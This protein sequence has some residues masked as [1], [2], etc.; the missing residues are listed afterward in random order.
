VIIVDAGG[1]TI[2]LS[3]YCMKHEPNW[4]EE[5]APSTCKP[6]SNH[7]ASRSP[8]KPDSR[9]FPGIRVCQS[10]CSDVL[11]EYVFL[12]SYQESE[13]LTTWFQDKL[14]D[15]QYGSPDDIAHIVDCFDKST[16]LAFKDPSQMAFIRFGSTRDSDSSVDIKLGQLKLRGFGSTLVSRT[17]DS[18]TGS[19][20]RK[21]LLSLNP[22]SQ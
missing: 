1:G 21:W 15:S 20:D 3:A 11:G 16:K 17:E 7:F 12:G 5:I 4:F 13:R 18:L 14:Y 19:T 2:D 6:L 8:T 9:S 22:A 10:S